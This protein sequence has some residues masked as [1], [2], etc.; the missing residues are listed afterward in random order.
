MFMN[1]MR[2]S[3]KVVML[4]MVV[5]FAAWLVLDGITAMQGGGI[6]G[7]SNPVVGTV[8]GRDIRLAEWN[9]FLTNRLA[10]ARG[11][12]GTMTDEEVFST[13]ED[14]WEGMIQAA[15]IQAQLDELGIVISDAEIQQAFLTRPPAEFMEYPA[16]RTDGEFDIRKYQ[17]FFTD[18]TTDEQTLLEMEN[19][20]R[21]ILPTSKLD[22]MV[23]SG[24]HV[25]DSEAWE[26][27]RDAN[28]TTR[29]RFVKLHPD[30]AVTDAEARTLITEDRI[31]AAYNERRED[32]I[33]PPT[34]TVNLVTLDLV[35]SAED[36]TEART[37]AQE[38]A[39]RLAAGEDFAELATAE[40]DDSVSAAVGG[41]M[42]WR[43]RT[44]YDPA[45]V[46]AAEEAG[47]DHFA[48]PVETAFGIHLLR[49][50]QE[51]AD[52]LALSQILVRVE[53]SRTTEDDFFDRL[54]LLEETALLHGLEAG[55]LAADTDVREDVVLI[56]GTSF[57]PGVGQ[58]SVGV[59]WAFGDDVL[60]G[61]V[62]EVY[63][64]SVGFNLLELVQVTPESQVSLEDARNN[65]E[66]Q[67]L[68]ET[69]AELAQGPARELLAAIQG[70]ETMDD[71]AARLELA[72]EEPP[73]FGRYDFV[74]GLGQRS[75]AIGASFGAAVG[76]VFVAETRDGPA[77]IEVLERME[78]DRAD[79]ESIA[80]FV[81]EQIRSQMAAAYAQQ[82][83]AGA[84][85][86]SLIEDHRARLD[87]LAEL[88]A[89]QVSF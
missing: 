71:A 17:Q 64:N 73:E 2:G 63:E 16:F 80:P 43:P 36:T 12:G 81:M 53:V 31:R 35:P 62:S 68:R 30:Q 22:E 13:T 78:V 58:L 55:A 9:A 52:S 6:A 23:L 86:T 37:R 54:E 79:Y 1:K 19:Y 65:L 70:G 56:D 61:D 82:W 45:L 83:I 34:A 44:T 49:T 15:L 3:A 41:Q 18:P 46:A 33:N 74:P 7:A 47:P 89:Q 69:K 60:P 42:G 67:L 39:D 85:E 26:F 77:V 32:L 76:A 20:Y 38:L 5:A 48:G 11:A 87:E 14:A 59:D 21:A 4:A 66:A 40:S 28:E 88:A 50:E 84:R 51:S 75:E 25:S 10:I 24:V 72:V 27:Y 29:V 57:V 8:G